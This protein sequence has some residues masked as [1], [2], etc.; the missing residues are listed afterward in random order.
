M[1]KTISSEKR[2]GVKAVVKGLVMV[3]GLGLIVYLGR[4]F[5]LG[6]ML[7]NTEWFNDHIIGHGPLAFLI[8]IVVGAVLSAA[9]LPR[10][11]VGFLGGFAFGIVGGTILSTIGSGLG[12][13]LASCYARWGGRD[14]VA[15]K[16]GPR[17]SR[18][19]GFLRHKPFRTALAI[20]FF[21][22][23]SNVLT[24]L[25]AGISSI[26]LIPFI[27]GSTLG[28]IPQN[29]IFAL[30]GAGMKEESTLGVA[31][32]LGMA[33]MLFLASI[34]LGMAIFRSYKKEATAA[35]LV[36]SEKDA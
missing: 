29:F 13:A 11:L 28:Y 12:C 14:L 4:S 19:D 8:F 15:R 34:W 3:A 27:L 26:P 16:L 31:L 35:G 32:S 30:F 6:D 23:G 24:N 25:A 7:K 36:S 18:L 5:G 9:G 1:T 10:Q 17:I 22:L 20:R 21:P 33:V 2:G